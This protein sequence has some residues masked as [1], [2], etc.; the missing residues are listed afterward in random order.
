MGQGTAWTRRNAVDSSVVRISKQ[1][2]FI[3]FSNPKTGSSSLR[4]FLDPYSD[5]FPVKNF[6]HRT[7]DN[8]F[9]PHITPNEVQEIFKRYQWNFHDYHKFVIV[10]NPWARLVS[11]YEHIKRGDKV[12]EFKEWLPNICAS[13]D[14]A[15]GESWQRWRRYGAWSIKNF[16]SDSDGQILVDKILRVEDLDCMLIPHLKKIGLDIPNGKNPE[17][18]NLGNYKQ[19]YS[20]Y[21]DE[22]TKALVAKNYQFD[23]EHFKYTFDQATI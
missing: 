13:G 3:F 16:I 21:Y 14:G 17:H 9:Y 6:L 1:Y 12:P 23:I 11:L 15:G 18:K 8:L 10:R 2:K 20:A 22:Q 19:H 5:L 7:P 4:Q